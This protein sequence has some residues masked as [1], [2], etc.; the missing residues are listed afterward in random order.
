MADGRIPIRFTQSRPPRKRKSALWRAG[1]S[2]VLLGLM[3]GL[4]AA[5][6]GFY[7]Y[8]KFAAPGPLAEAKMVVIDKGI[9]TVEI[10]RRLE[11]AGV[12]SDSR[13]FAVATFLSGARGRLK[14]GEYRFEAKVPMSEVV[15]LLASGKSLIYKL[16]VPEGWTSD[17]V[18]ARISEN[19]VL[20][21]EITAPPAEGE[22]LP[23]TYLFQRGLARQKLIDE[24][25]AAQERVLA[26]AWAKRNPSVSLSSPRDALI[27]ASIVE[28]ETAKPAERP[29]IASVFLNRLQRGMRLQ[30]DPTIIY[31]IVGGKGK[32]DRKLTRKD[33][34]TLTPYNTY[35]IDGLPPGPIGNPGRA[36]IEAVLNPK[37][38]VYLYFVADGTGGHAFASTLAE[39]NRNVAKWRD[40]EGNAATAAAAEDED[41]TAKAAQGTDPANLP[42]IQ[43][44]DAAPE[45]GT[46]STE[47]TEASQAADA[48][49]ET[50]GS[51]AVTPPAAGEILELKPGS[52]IWASGR[53]IPI[54]KLKPAQ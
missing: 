5:G 12:I 39:H 33:I 20:S 44:D 48:P 24:M 41:E 27:L 4:M 53:Q 32:L 50:S 10:G 23:E 49:T 7:G 51:E 2:I 13:V 31:G 1:G 34:K 8:L 15:D 26:E 40:I 30:S 9:G 47:T 37:E 43:V 3:L 14:A 29:L 16:S 42:E 11:D 18:L 19:D 36:A 6:L 46:T 25:K 21:G 54:P 38:S 22:I 35:M 52:V 45:A 28:R 17:M